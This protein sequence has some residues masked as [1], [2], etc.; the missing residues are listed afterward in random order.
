MAVSLSA[1][2][3]PNRVSCTV[4]GQRGKPLDDLSRAGRGSPSLR[5]ARSRPPAGGN[6]RPL[7]AVPLVEPA[8]GTGRETCATENSSGA[9]T[10]LCR[11][12]AGPADTYST[13]DYLCD[14]ETYQMYP[15]LVRLYS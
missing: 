5:L 6:V 15:Y 8:F 12:Q 3:A 1:P 4:Y 11:H 7:T 9:I 13:V 14:D 2:V 10:C